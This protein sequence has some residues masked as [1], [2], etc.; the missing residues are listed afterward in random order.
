MSRTGDRKDPVPTAN[1]RAQMC[2]AG[3]VLHHP[4]ADLLIEYATVGCPTKIGNNWLMN[5]LEEAINVG[6]HVSA[7]NPKVM[8]Q[9][10]SEVKEKEAL[11]Q[12]SWQQMQ[13][14]IFLVIAHQ[15]WY[16]L[17]QCYLI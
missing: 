6:P 16:D 11:G 1:H 10:Q 17:Q 13:L 14:A 8:E 15:S 2:P 7:L 9:L 5:D 12:A 3:L 4:A